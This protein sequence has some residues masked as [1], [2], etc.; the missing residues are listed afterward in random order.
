[1][2]G[3]NGPGKAGREEGIGR[4][5]WAKRDGSRIQRGSVGL[6]EAVK[7]LRRPEDWGRSEGLEETEGLGFW[8]E[9]LGNQAVPGNSMDGGY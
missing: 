1:M 6:G 5:E 9:Y 7:V 8:E 3:C 2:G 4:Q